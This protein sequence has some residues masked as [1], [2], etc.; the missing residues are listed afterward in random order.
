MNAAEIRRPLEDMIG[1][2]VDGLSTLPVP[3]QAT[4]GGNRLRLTSVELALPVE[5]R[6]L[7]GPSGLVVHA[8]MPTTRT[9]TAFD[10]PVNRFVLRLAATP[11]QAAP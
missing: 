5:T 11:T 7:D 4:I 6:V 2:L 3:G 8:D 1:E 9:R 10:L